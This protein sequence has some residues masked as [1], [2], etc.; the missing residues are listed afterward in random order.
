MAE[1]SKKSILLA[2]KFPKLSQELQQLLFADGETELAAQVP[3]LT[4]LDRCR[5]GDDFC[6]TFYIQPKPAGAYGPGHRCLSLD[7]NEGMLIVDVLDEKIAAVEILHRNE[8]RQELL[9]EFP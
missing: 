2:A 3:G 4:I 6:A 8:I 7:P 9:A 1:Q 5:C